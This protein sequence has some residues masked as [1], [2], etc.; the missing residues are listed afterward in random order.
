MT[1]DLQVL[2]C[3]VLTNDDFDGARTL[4]AMKKELRARGGDLRHLKYGWHRRIDLEGTPMQC[5]MWC[6]LSKEMG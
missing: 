2:E 5:V 1:A 3:T 6:N 4:D